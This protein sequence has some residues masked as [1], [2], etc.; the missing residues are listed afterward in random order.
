MKKYRQKWFLW[1]NCL[2]D[3]TVTKYREGRMCGHIHTILVADDSCAGI[4]FRNLQKKIF[5]QTN[6]A[7]ETFKASHF[8]AKIFT[9][10]C[11]VR[12]M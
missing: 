11:F 10:R 5:I 3:F 12:E 1:R 8:K 2:K 6:N 7:A 4:G 9:T